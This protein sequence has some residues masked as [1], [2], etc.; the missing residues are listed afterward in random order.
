MACFTRNPGPC[1]HP[2][3]NM[4]IKKKCSHGYDPN[5]ETC[6]KPSGRTNPDDRCRRP[7][8]TQVDQRF[9]ERMLGDCPSD[10][11]LACNGVV[12]QVSKPRGWAADDFEEINKRMKELKP[13]PQAQNQEEIYGL[14]DPILIGDRF[15]CR[16]FWAQEQS[17]GHGYGSD[18]LFCHYDGPDKECQVANRCLAKDR[19]LQCS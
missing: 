14:P 5:Q 15:K 19:G 7:G 9:C 6:P 2:K 13:E 1:G 17:E 12:E 8:Y 10:C 16:W 11:P 4:F 3:C 18:H